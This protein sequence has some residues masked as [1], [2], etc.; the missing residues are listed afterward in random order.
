MHSE[1]FPA[2]KATWD[3]MESG[4]GKSACDGVGGAIKNYADTAVKSGTVIGNAQEFF[5]WAIESNDRMLCVFV[6]RADVVLAERILR[7]ACPVK[8]MSKCHTIRAF[9]G[10]LFIR[11]KSCY[12]DCCRENPVCPGWV[13]TPV[14]EH[15]YESE[16]ETSQQEETTDPVPTY[17]VGSKVEIN[18]NSKVYGALVEE[19][20]E[21][22][23]EYQ[24]KFMKKNRSGVYC[25]PRST[26]SVWIHVSD[27][28]KLVE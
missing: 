26:W 19:F 18:Y 12:Q 7:N 3:F 5:D 20:D 22:T 6:S 17:T 11:D 15:G 14:T 25:C 23:N 27:I 1:Y 8:G 9:N 28:I 24:V 10:H 4:H 21:D 16:D 13:K 2:I